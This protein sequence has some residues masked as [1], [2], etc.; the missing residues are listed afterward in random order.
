MP[1]PTIQET[2]G[3]IAEPEMRFTSQGKAVLSIRLAFNDSRYNEETRQWENSKTFYVDATAWEQTAE[4]LADQIRKG[5]QVYVSGRLETQ[6][7]EKD[8]EKKSKPSLTVRTMRKLE[9]NAPTQHQG[10]GNFAPAQSAGFGAPQPP[11]PSQQDPW[12]GGQ[13]QPA[14]GEPAQGGPAPF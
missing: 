7:W 2:A 12:G 8:G 9:K 13:Q 4:R 1:I 5:D 14:W 6:S 3:V 11:A 10:G